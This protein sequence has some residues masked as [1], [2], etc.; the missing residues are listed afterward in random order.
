MSKGRELDIL[1]KKYS[2][3]IFEHDGSVVLC[4]CCSKGFPD[5]RKFTLDQH[6]KT[7]LHKQNEERQRNSKNKVQQLTPS[8][9][10][11]RSTDP[12]PMDLCHALM[13]A[14]IPLHKLSNPVFKEFLEKYVSKKIPDESTLRKT[15]VPI[16]YEKTLHTI[17]EAIGQSNIWLSIDEST[18]TQGR[19]VAHVVV[20][21]L[22]ATG[23]SKSYLLSCEQLEKTDATS[24]GQ[25]F[26]S[27]LQLLWNG[28][29]H[30]G[31][32]LLFVTDAAPYM[33]KA[34]GSLQVLFPKMTHVTCVA[35]GLH[36]VAEQ[37]R[38]T[39]P[40]VDQLISSVKKIFVKAPS[41]VQA[42]KEAANIELPPAPVLTRWGT[43]ILA[44]LY[45]AHNFDV[46]KHFVC[47]NLDPEDAAAIETAQTLFNKRSLKDDLSI[48]AANFSVLPSAIGSLEEHGL[49]LADA[50]GKVKEVE[51]QF[52]SFGGPKLI[53]IK[54]K[55]S[56]VLKKNKGFQYLSVVQT[57]L[58]GSGSVANLPPDSAAT[59]SPAE[60]ACL[61]FA[62]V[63][64]C[65]VERTFSRF[66]SIFRDNRHRFLFEH[67]KMHVVV[68]CNSQM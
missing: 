63:V 35:H 8:L 51:I 27:A 17:R 1:L 21:K 52:N 25:L 2:A 16:N 33:A 13:S 7:A 68:A 29:L 9:M 65:D 48:I 56:K 46:V 58:D 4:T 41:R 15:Y 26:I 20:G 57:I 38:A 6:L 47:T 53:P 60:L 14:D 61:R 5:A 23:S 40:D 42:F 3:G 64:S 66:K 37:I 67:L 43:W 12:F 31:R 18:D 59:L 55:L 34:A 19:Y 49:C 11:G 28:E 39:F 24:I 32:V 54:E 10:G 50:I 62:P 22:E 36:R 44:A 30:H 45:H